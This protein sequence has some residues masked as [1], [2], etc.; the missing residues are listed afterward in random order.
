M[1]LLTVAVPPGPAPPGPLGFFSTSI[2]LDSSRAREP[3]DFSVDLSQKIIG[4]GV[5]HLHKGRKMNL[6]SKQPS[7]V[8]GARVREGGGEMGRHKNREVGRREA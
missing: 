4:S 6:S 7:R 5:C 2:C 3:L 1:H 8:L